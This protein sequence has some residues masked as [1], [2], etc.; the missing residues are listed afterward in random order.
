[1]QTLAIGKRPNIR[2]N[3]LR[4]CILSPKVLL[5]SLRSILIFFRIRRLGN[6]VAVKQQT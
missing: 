1:M 6:A 4:R 2:E 3:A 5:Q